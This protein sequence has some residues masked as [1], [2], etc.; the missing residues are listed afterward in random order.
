MSGKETKE[1]SLIDIRSMSQRD[2][3]MIPVKRKITPDGE[4][5][6][7]NVNRR[8]LFRMDYSCDH[9]LSKKSCLLVIAHKYCYRKPT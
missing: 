7:L 6:N 9:R 5:K 8:M 2:S 4:K 3:A 1:Y